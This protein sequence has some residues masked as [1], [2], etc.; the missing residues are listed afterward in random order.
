MDANN[1]IKMANQIG[2]FFESQPNRAEAQEAVLS[3]IEKFWDP[4]MRAAFL[5]SLDTDSANDLSDFV[6]EA[7]KNHRNLLS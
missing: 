6:K 1:L 4:R 2:T 5:K 7:I 3:H